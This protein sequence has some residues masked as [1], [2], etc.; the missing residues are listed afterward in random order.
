L[1]EVIWGTLPFVLL[2]ML[3][4]AAAVLLPGHFDRA[5]GPGDG[6]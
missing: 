2:M 6:A 1:S 3:A 5:A 4:G